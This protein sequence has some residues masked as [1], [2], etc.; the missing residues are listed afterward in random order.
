MTITELIDKL[1]QMPGEAQ[2]VII[3]PGDLDGAYEAFETEANSND[4]EYC[5]KDNTVMIGRW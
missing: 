2:V 3:V 5:P 1:K 4:I